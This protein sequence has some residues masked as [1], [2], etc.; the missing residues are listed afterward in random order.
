MVEPRNQPPILSCRSLSYAYDN[1]REALFNLDF[2][3]NQGEFLAVLAAN[4]SGKTTLLKILAGLLKP[5]S[6]EVFF[7]G[8]DLNNLKRSEISRRV[9]LVMQNP[10][11][12]LFSMTVKEDLAF[13]PRNQGLSEKE[14]ESRV[15]EALITVD[16]LDLKDRAIHRI[17][18]GEQKRIS[19]AGVLAMRPSI[20]LLDEVTSGL[21]PKGEAEMIALLKA[22]NQRLKVTIVFATH[23]IDPLPLLADKILVLYE[24]RGAALDSCETVL[25]NKEMLEKAG[26]RM[27]LMANLFYDLKV[28]E[29]IKIG[30]LPLEPQ[31]AREKIVELINMGASAPEG[32]ENAS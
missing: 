14:I 25:S 15:E 19:L 21:D 29:G 8:V 2:S 30:N 5:K 11:D 22:L 18:F 16:A 4:G 28:K 26:L 20:L 9:G 7:D 32:N 31:K 10:K 13:G 12:Q 6:G 3:I 27:P 24:G 17:S 1:G 23:S